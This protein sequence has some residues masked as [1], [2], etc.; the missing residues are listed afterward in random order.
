MLRADLWEKKQ[1]LILYLESYVFYCI[2]Y[3]KLRGVLEV[4]MLRTVV[5]PSLK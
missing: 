1:S 5:K 3:V 4:K 2:L